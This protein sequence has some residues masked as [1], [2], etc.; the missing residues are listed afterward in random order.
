M[1]K[2][3]PSGKKT[4]TQDWLNQVTSEGLAWWYMDDGSLSITSTNSPSIRL[5]TQ[6]FSIE[7][8]QLL[9]AW[10][11]DWGYAAKLHYARKA[12][13]RY[14][15]IYMGARATRQWISDLKAFSIPAM[16]YKFRA[17]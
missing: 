3:E 12:E 9:V 6:R 14:P 4:V 5:H 17:N 11:N 1:V 2:P 8:N 13:K 10:L 7:E 15:Y 16:A